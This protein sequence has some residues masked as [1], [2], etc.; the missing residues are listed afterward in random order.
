MNINLKSKK[1]ANMLRPKN[2]KLLKKGSYSLAFTVVILAIAVFLN[3]LIGELPSSATKIDVSENKLYSIGDETKNVASSL[4]EDVTLYLLAED[5]S[6]DAT[7]NELLTRYADL[8]SHIKYEKKDPVLNPSFASSYTDEDLAS[9]SVIVVSD[10]RSKVIPYSD[11][12]ESSVNYQTYSMETTAFDGEGQVTSAIAYV[13]TEDLPILYTLTGHEENDLDS[14]MQSAIE[15]ENIEVQELNL[16][17]AGTV[18]EDAS[19]LMINA[20]QK[21]FSDDETSAILTYL[22]NGGHAFLVSGYTTT[23]MPNYHSILEQY[24]VSIEKGVVLEGDN[25]HYVSGNPLY[26][27]PEIQSCDATGSLSGSNSYVLMPIG[28]SIKTLDSKSDDITVTDMLTST[29][30]AYLKADP[31][32][33][34]S[35]SKE[36]NDETGPFTLAAAITEAIGN[37]SDSEEETETE[38]IVE[39]ESSASQVEAESGNR[40]LPKM[41]RNQAGRSCKQSVS[42]QQYRLC[43]F[44]RQ[45]KTS[46]KR[47]K[48]DV[49]TEFQYLHSFQE[50]AAV[51]SDPDICKCQPLEHYYH[52]RS[53]GSV[54]GN[55]RCDLAEKEEKIMKKKII[56][57]GCGRCCS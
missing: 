39:G 51:L 44:R 37:G 9:N 5:G 16:L 17:T 6:E 48:L 11:L 52:C 42:D 24:G 30:S 25:N 57:T 18:P 26:L 38:T 32:N 36:E 46:H 35:L 40:S 28:Q 2:K 34:E 50:Y 33:M 45:Y 56:W 7:L 47:F 12:Y 8:S 41:Q 14:S 10:K 22:Q 55:R 43:C 27:V 31:E 15:K 53:S 29:S 20:P 13:T 19:C 1:P 3:L 23:E 49:R 54:P 4:T 21:D